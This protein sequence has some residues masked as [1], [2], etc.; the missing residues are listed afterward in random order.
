MHREYDGCAGGVFALS[1]KESKAAVSLELFPIIN[2][3]T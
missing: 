1:R 2:A 3:L